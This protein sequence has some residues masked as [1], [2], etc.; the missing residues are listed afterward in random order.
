MRKSFTLIELLV[1]IA[2]IAIL[3]AMLLPALSKARDKARAISCVNNMKQIGLYAMM[4]CN[5]NNDYL[6]PR[7][8]TSTTHT[9]LCDWAEPKTSS[10]Q[11]LPFYFSNV[12]FEYT[13][14]GKGILRCPGDGTSNASHESYGIAYYLTNAPTGHLCMITQLKAPTQMVLFGE[15][16]RMKDLSWRRYFSE[17][18][19][20]PMR[21]R[22]NGNTMMNVVSCDGSVH[23][24]NREGMKANYYFQNSTTDSSKFR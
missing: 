4:Y 9:N 18:T 7:W 21:F 11:S 14:P 19:G 16:E 15:T 22:H 13:T 24:T 1:V 6:V 5:D 8:S 23:T 17:T 3:A 2:I 12:Y 20:D 10:S